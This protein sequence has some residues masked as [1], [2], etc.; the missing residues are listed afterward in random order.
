MTER[1]L[2][3]EG[4]KPL[5][6]QAEREGLWFYQSYTGLWLSPDDLRK[7]QSNGSYF[8]GACNWKLRSPIERLEQLT[9]DAD[10]AI[11]EREKFR[12]RILS[13]AVVPEGK[14]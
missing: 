11:A 10:R 8:W 7:E 5:F 9:H 13:Q 6:E 14:W 4:L 1:E 3:I 2:V 12:E